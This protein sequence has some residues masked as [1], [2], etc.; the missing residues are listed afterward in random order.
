MIMIMIIIIWSKKGREGRRTRLPAGVEHSRAAAVR[1]AS[2]RRPSRNAAAALRHAPPPP[3][4]SSSA[5]TQQQH[6]PAPQR[7][8][9]AVGGAWGG[10]GDTGVVGS[11]RD[12]G[13]VP[14]PAPPAPLPPPPP[15]GGVPP[16]LPLPP[17]LSPAPGR[18]RGSCPP[19][20]GGVQG[21]YGGAL[22]ELSFS[23]RGRG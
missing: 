14:I 18:H 10:G 20:D 17:S 4:Q 9:D 2:T 23:R 8:C 21:K 1:D 16:K 13:C 19:R 6:F 15:Q 12:A 7:G 3:P 5:A 11:G 22:E